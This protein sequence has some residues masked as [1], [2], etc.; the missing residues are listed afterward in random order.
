MMVLLER[1]CSFSGG[2]LKL[3]L[4]KK[5]NLHFLH[6]EEVKLSLPNI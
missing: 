6:S 4:F 1:E 5:Q 2:A 3:L